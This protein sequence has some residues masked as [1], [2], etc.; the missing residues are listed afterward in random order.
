MNRKQAVE[1][2]RQASIA[3]QIKAVEQDV[4]SAKAA[5]EQ[6]A[7]KLVENPTDAQTLRELTALDDEIKGHE[8]KI[9]WLR[10]ASVE[11]AKQDT[12]EFRRYELERL[13]VEQQRV[14]SGMDRQR[15]VAAALVAHIEAIGPL[16]AEYESLAQDT[17]AAAWTVVRGSCGKEIKVADRH[18]TQGLVDQVR[19][20]AAV[21]H[22]VNA[23]YAA[24]LG[25]TG[26]HLAPFVEVSRSPDMGPLDEYMRDHQGR[27]LAKLSDLVSRREAE[28]AGAPTPA[29]PTAA[30]RFIQGGRSLE[31]Q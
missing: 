30:D 25:R 2:N 1:S 5:H 12:A 20:R 21:P 17:Q 10:S 4:A 16:L 23:L 11:A 19:G 24:G 8:R 22:V 18:W 27:V 6:A 9:A 15:E 7:L 31:K 3:Q 26:L 13:K 29:A 14:E 28:L